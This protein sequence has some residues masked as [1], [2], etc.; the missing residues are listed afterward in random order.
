MINHSNHQPTKKT[1]YLSKIRKKAINTIILLLFFSCVDRLSNEPSIENQEQIVVDGLLTDEPGPHTVRIFRSYNFYSN[2]QAKI[3]IPLSEIGIYDNLGNKEQLTSVEPGVYQT[4]SDFRGVV[5]R[6]YMIKFTDL[7]GNRYESI[8]DKLNPNGHLDSLY[9]TFQ[10]YRPLVG[11]TQYSFKVLVDA[12]AIDSDISYY[13]WRYQGTYKI[14][15]YPEHRRKVS[16]NNFNIT[17]PDPPPCANATLEP[18]SIDKCECCFCWVTLNEDKPFVSGTKKQIT[19]RL[20]TFELVDIPVEKFVFGDKFRLEVKQMSLSKTAYEFW[21]A[22]QKQI[23]GASSLFQPPGSTPPGN[24]ISL[25]KEI[26]VDGIFYAA[27]VETKV[28]YITSFDVRKYINL[29]PPDSVKEDCRIF[30]ASINKK[31]SYW[32]D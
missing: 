16:F 12:K 3:P 26:V 17:F 7:K 21:D 5:G 14:R 11:P 28:K 24:I 2:L 4:S 9:Y 15:T 25:D 19:S 8:P 23:E 29:P 27:S 13:R 30:P 1:C 32:E 6:T 22:I 20:G 10:S 31:P 18:F